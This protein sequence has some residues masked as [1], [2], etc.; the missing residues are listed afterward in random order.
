MNEALGVNVSEGV[1]YGAENVARF[2]GR[3]R[4]TRNHLREIFFG[5]FHH[6]V[7]HRRVVEFAAAHFQE[8]DQVGM[9]KFC[10]SFPASE[11]G[12]GVDRI[13]GD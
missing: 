6:D 3:K 11:L 9:R 5:V 4:S 7:K 10:G 8:A 2:R 1:D 12:W 13:G